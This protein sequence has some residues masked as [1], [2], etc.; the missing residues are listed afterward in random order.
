MY[1]K[2]TA[3]YTSLFK[4]CD[5][6]KDSLSKL[7]ILQQMAECQVKC[8]HTFWPDLVQIIEVCEELKYSPHVLSN[9]LAKEQLDKSSYV[10]AYVMYVAASKMYRK[11]SRSKDCTNIAAVKGISSC[12][13]QLHKILNKLLTKAV[14]KKIALIQVIPSMNEMLKELQDV[15][16][17][18]RVKKVVMEAT[19][20]TRMGRVYQKVGVEASA[21]NH[22]NRALNIMQKGIGMN[23]PKHKIYGGLLHNIGIVYEVEHEYAQAIRNYQESII[24][25]EKAEDYDDPKEKE[26]NIENTWRALQ[27]CKEK[28]NK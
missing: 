13:H 25:K 28:L 24:A 14:T 15:K 9:S 16:E 1:S 21:H 4:Q 3:T 27:S 8:E 11:N 5:N 23:F 20:L 18:D 6:E 7:K 22:Y 19:F 2:W 26:R 10:R 12:I 17:L